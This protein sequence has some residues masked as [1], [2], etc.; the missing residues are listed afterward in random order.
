MSNLEYDVAITP[1][2]IFQAGSI[3]KQFTAFAIALL[4]SEGKLAFGDDIRRYLPELPDFQQ[5]ITI[6]HLL[7]HSSG[8]RNSGNLARLAGDVLINTE[9]DALKMVARTKSLNFVPG[10]EYDY[11]NTGFMLLAVIV[12]R[13]SGQSL[14]EFA[15]TRIFG[16]LGMRDT[17]FQD[18]HT[19]I[20]RRRTSAYD[21]RPGGGWKISIPVSDAVGASNLFTTVGDLLKWEQN[22][23]EARVG[24]RALLDEM[25]AAGRLNDGTATNYGFGLM[26]GTYR[27]ARTVG[28]GGWDFGY[29]AN[30][31]RFPDQHLA[32]AMLCNLATIG[33]TAVLTR[34]V[35][36]IILGPDALAPLPSPLS[37]T[38]TEIAGL[39]GTYW[40]PHTDLDW[41]VIM[42]DGQLNT[43]GDVLTPLGGGRFRV[44]DQPDDEP[45]EQLLFPMSQSTV[46]REP[47]LTSPCATRVL[48][49]VIAPSYSVSDLKRY[50]GDYRSDEL[51]VSYTVVAAPEGRLAILRNKVDPIQLQ[52]LKL[53]TFVG[54]SLG[55]V[56]FVHAPSG[57]ITGLTITTGGVRRLLLTRI[58]K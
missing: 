29:K 44:G 32:I 18:D 46:P 41:P 2:S 52:A 19:M 50:A 11:S 1:D 38:Q 16:P 37:M 8:L 23:V 58:E 30:V 21:R 27:G 28:H 47:R 20:V 25:Q 36:E 4:A 45:C 49:R 42:Q 55:K 40:D 43:Y 13:A 5:R 22:F 57:A 31:V 7:T 24:G 15:E 26:V 10:A 48:M 17:H 12:K 39:V 3:S 9:D 56:T 51:D 33:T 34:K 53:D 35:A 6:R 54:A 14:R